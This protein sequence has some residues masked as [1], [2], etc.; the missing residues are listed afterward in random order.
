MRRYFVGN[1]IQ[2]EVAEYYR[3]FTADLTKRF[4]VPNLSEKI[5][6]HFTL[7]P[8]FETDDVTP[9]AAEVK[10]VAASCAPIPFYVKGFGGFGSHTIYLSILP[11]PEFQETAERIV[12]ALNNFGENKRMLPRP[13]HPHLSL[14]RAYYSNQQIIN[15]I[16]DYV[17]TLPSPTFELIFDNLTLFEYVDHRWEIYETCPFSRRAT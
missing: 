1:L 15:A 2:G 13:F 17:Q 16:W 10:D 5:P 3:A 6:A 9:F 11:H 4:K 8:P 12:D 7:K 14:A